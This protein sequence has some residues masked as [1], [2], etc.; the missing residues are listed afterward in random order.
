MNQS[1]AKS[2]M[3]AVF[4]DDWGVQMEY[5]NADV[6]FI[7]NDP[8]FMYRWLNND[9]T[10][11]QTD[12]IAKALLDG[13]NVKS[14]LDTVR[15]LFNAEIRQQNETA[16]RVQYLE[17][18]SGLSSREFSIINNWFDHSCPESIS[19]VLSLCEPMQRQNKRDS[20]MLQNL[21]TFLS[22]AL[23]RVDNC[24]QKVGCLPMRLSDGLLASQKSLVS[25][26]LFHTIC[27]SFEGFAEVIP[28]A[29]LRSKRTESD[30]MR[31]KEVLFKNGTVPNNTLLFEGVNRE[32][33]QNDHVESFVADVKRISSTDGGNVNLL[34][35]ELER[36][37]EQVDNNCGL[38]R[39]TD[40]TEDELS[41]IGHIVLSIRLERG[42]NRNEFSELLD[43][44]PNAILLVENVIASSQI[45]DKVVSAIREKLKFDITR[46]VYSDVGLV[47]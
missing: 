15:E 24:I 31:Y 5:S 3:E 30:V 42:E 36:L 19:K 40:F 35:R 8:C 43:V 46:L 1:N 26:S 4:S 38:P 22:F 13:E 34:P 20:K 47:L 28:S 2:F 39:E 27:M 33:S 17:F 12:R 16:R 21:R 7:G 18:L 44:D 32:L 45:L 29:F 41:F 11:S 6:Y 37:V 14:I 10:W 9:R 23:E 25:V